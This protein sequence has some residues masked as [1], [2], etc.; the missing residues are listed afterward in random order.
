MLLEI[1]QT[2]R[3]QIKARSRKNW[4]AEIEARLREAP[5]VRDFKRALTG[6][7]AAFIFEIKRR[8][9]ANGD[10]PI[11]VDVAQ[12]AALYQL[13]G[14]SCIS[15]LTEPDYFAGSLADL[16]TVRGAVELPLLRKDFIVDQLQIAEARAL[17][18]DAV[19]LIVALLATSQLADY[20]AYCRETE[21]AALVEV[22]TE[23]ELEQA[24]AAEAEIIGVNNRNLTTLEIDLS[25]GQHLLSLIPPDCVRV[26]ESGIKSRLDILPLRRSGA[27]AFLIGSTV[28]KAADR[29]RKIRELMGDDES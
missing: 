29:E 14:A 4:Q 27:D 8:S 11:D 13:S 16:A 24:L 22:H 10:R 2:V 26:A 7:D 3:D 5:P 19:L 21:L 12:L 1:A 28:M 23:A 18:A 6:P 9:P 25:V 20:L 15:V 17:G